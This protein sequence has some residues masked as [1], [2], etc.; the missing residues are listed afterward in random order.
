MYANLET[1]MAWRGIVR[2]PTSDPNDN[3]AQAEDGSWYV[4]DA[5]HHLVGP[6]LTY[7]AACH[8]AWPEISARM[9]PERIRDY[10]LRWWIEMLVAMVLG[11]MLFYAMGAVRV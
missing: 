6:F 9:K 5:R 10:D 7:N 2:A 4:L 3:P 11:A 1:A 8:A